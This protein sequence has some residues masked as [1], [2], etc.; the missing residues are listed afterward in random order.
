MVFVGWS[1]YL[2]GEGRTVGCDAAPLRRLHGA[3]AV[4]HS[5]P[6]AFRARGC[7]GSAPLLGC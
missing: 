6:G 1:L 7:C 3:D 5:V 2:L 4:C